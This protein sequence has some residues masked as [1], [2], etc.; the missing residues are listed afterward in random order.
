MK[1]LHINQSDISGGAAI[2]AFR[3]HQSLLKHKIQSNLLVDRV[4][5]RSENIDEIDRRRH[6]EDLASRV[7]WRFGL[8]YIYVKSTTPTLNHHFYK[9]ATILNFHNLHGGYFNYLGIPKL[10]KEK[11]AVFT[12]HDM[13]SFTGHCAYS[14]NC[15]RWQDG[16]GR[17]PDLSSYPAIK[18]DT[19]HLEWTLKKWVY[20][21]SNLT[22]VTPSR[23]L[24]NLAHRSILGHF[25]IHHIPNGLDIEAYQPLD[26][27]ICRK[28]LGIALDK[29]VLMF[30]AQNLRDPRKGGKFLV[31]ALQQL[32][33]SLKQDMILLLLGD[34]G[35]EIGSSAGI[36]LVSLGSVAGDRLKAIAYSA[37]DL[38]VLPTRADNLPLV[39][40]ESMACGTPVVALDVG[41]VSDLV[42]PNITGYLAEAENSSSLTQKIRLVLEDSEMRETMA[43]NCRQIA[44]SEYSLELQAKRYINLYEEILS[45]Y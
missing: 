18:R 12:L 31:E 43:Q 7:F 21:R 1:V 36:A 41:G 28:A 29:K 26:Q 44:I 37:A 11:P 20:S 19:T 45:R 33:Q 2:A 25:Q 27:Q 32:P 40:Q 6:I 24:E 16:C 17:C 23:W 8:N 30:A 13:W 5:V 34:G 39:L 3:L 38:F 42:R 35:E 15:D 22:I 4:T 14:F 10:T 9:E